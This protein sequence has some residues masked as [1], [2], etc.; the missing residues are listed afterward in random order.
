MTYYNDDR[1]FTNYVHENIAKKQIY[2]KL[3][4]I[5]QDINTI[6][7][8]NVDINNSVDYFAIDSNNNKIITIQE[9]FREKKYLNYNDFTIR[10]KRIFNKDPNRKLSEFFKLNVNYFVYGIID[11]SKIDVNEN[12]KFVKYAIINIEKLLE[13]IDNGRIIIDESL[14]SKYC[15]IEDN[16]LRCPVIENYDHSSS[17]VPFDIKI[18]K[19]L[20]DKEIIIYSE[21]F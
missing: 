7:A 20:F 21:G 19:N 2:P 9:R 10:Y 15:K 16:I 8:E 4:W 18:L 6:V 14:Q 17:F 5:I 11:Q 13:M 3:N 12:G 1:K